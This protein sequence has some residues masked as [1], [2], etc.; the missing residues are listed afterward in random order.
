MKFVK[1]NKKRDFL[2]E[3]LDILLKNEIENEAFIGI[4]NELDEDVKENGSLLGRI[5]NDEDEQILFVVDNKEG[6]VTYFTSD[7]IKDDVIDFFVENLLEYKINFKQMLVNTKYNDRVVDIYTRK[8]KSK[9]FANTCID[10]LA[11]TQMDQEQVLDKNEKLIKVNRETFNLDKLNKVVRTIYSDIYKE[12]C[13]DEIIDKIVDVYLNK[14]IYIL[15]N[16]KEEEVYCH[17]VTVRKQVHGCTI[18]ALVSPKEHRGRGYGK[19]FIYNLCKK[20]LEDNNQF[21]ILEV[22]RQNYVARIVYEK[23]GFKKSGEF[24]KTFFY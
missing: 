7:N 15:T 3:N 11:I 10:I 12:E 16:D 19:K 8:S 6:L 17:A 20:L 22:A 1:Y 21:I 4:I 23:V 5:D 18:G 24:V 13:S 2:K 9:I 14:G